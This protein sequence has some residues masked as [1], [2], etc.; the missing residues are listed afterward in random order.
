MSESYYCNHC[1]Q[2]AET[3]SYPLE[4]REPLIWC[5][6]CVLNYKSL[7]VEAGVWGED[8][9]NFLSGAR[10]FTFWDPKMSDRKAKAQAISPL[11]NVC[12]QCRSIHP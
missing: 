8:D 5:K 4:G 9:T 1:G 7:L 6:S 12:P 11:E 2:K 10:Q 3:G